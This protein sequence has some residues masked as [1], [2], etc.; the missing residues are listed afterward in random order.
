MKQG[1]IIVESDSLFVE[2]EQPLLHEFD[3]SQ[4]H[5]RL[6]LDGADR[7]AK[8]DDAFPQILS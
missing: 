4:P 2:G 5:F 6:S 3:L 7:T 1:V 8:I